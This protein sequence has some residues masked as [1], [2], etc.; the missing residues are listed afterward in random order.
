MKPHLLLQSHH[1]FVIKS[2]CLSQGLC[3]A[4]GIRHW[5]PLPVLRDHS[6][7]DLTPAVMLMLMFLQS[8]IAYPVNP[9][10][11]ASTNNKPCRLMVKRMH[12][13]RK[14]LRRATTLLLRAT[15]S[16]GAKSVKYVE[17]HRDDWLTAGFGWCA[18]TFTLLF[19]K[20]WLC[21]DGNFSG[22]EK[23]MDREM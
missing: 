10:L 3:A 4:P 7:D 16:Q 17:R 12:S 1:S 21:P 23:V 14:S 20:A 19:W 15:S 22:K 8:K 18:A 6:R 13:V 11:A 2:C 9:L 5:L